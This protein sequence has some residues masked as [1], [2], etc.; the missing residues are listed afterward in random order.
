MSCSHVIVHDARL[1]GRVF[2]REGVA[3][4]GT[5]ARTPLSTVTRRIR[6]LATAPE[7]VMTHIR[8][9][10][11]G[12]DPFPVLTLMAHGVRVTDDPSGTDTA[13]EIGSEYIH[14]GNALRFGQTIRGCVLDKIRVLG[15]AAAETESGRRMCSQLSVGAGV[16]LFASAQTQNFTTSE[17]HRQFG[18]ITEGVWIDF[19]AWE[20]EVYRFETDGSHELAWR[21]PDP[22]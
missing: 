22:Q 19:G 2:P 21:G 8:T 14:E 1:V 16:R 18:R 12:R 5:D 7:A 15:C 11:Y 17:G 13:L 4:I 6:D 20:G 9:G 3:I 10:R